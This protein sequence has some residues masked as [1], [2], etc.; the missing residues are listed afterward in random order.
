MM[1]T[2]KQ[3]GMVAALA[4]LGACGGG[5][6][7]ATTTTDT[8]G[9]AADTS[10]GEVTIACSVPNAPENDAYQRGARLVEQGDASGVALLDGACT[11]GNPCACSELSEVYWEGR[12]APTDHDRAITLADIAC[13]GGEIFGCWHAGSMRWLARPNE[14]DLAISRY[15]VACEGE[16]GEAC[17]ELGRLGLSGISSA[18]ATDALAF[19]DTACQNDTPLA[20]GFQGA[21][22]SEGEVPANPQRG[23]EL[24][25]FACLEALVPSACT[26]M[27]RLVVAANPGAA[28][29]A[30]QHA[31]DLHDVFACDALLPEAEAAAMQGTAAEALDLDGTG[32]EHA[33]IVAASTPSTI[34][35]SAGGDLDVAQLGLRPS[36]TGIIERE[37]DL[38]V[39]V[40]AGVPA[41]DLSIAALTDTTL[42][43]RDPAGGWHCAD[44]APNG[45]YQPSLHVA[46]PLAG[47]WVVWVGR[48]IHG[49]TQ[50][51]VRLG[52]APAAP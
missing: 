33:A 7:T 6:S 30:W 39:D 22:L 26:E 1:G 21:A 10:G 17:L 34:E 15:D 52:S 14:T 19:Y 49:E 51:T 43:V 29:E 37:A 48:F 18:S 8:G 25:E 40:G 24:L 11:A 47:E 31:C 46:T 28:R 36:C 20:C 12:L 50:A 16:N 42:V 41:L 44:D 32:A 3:T 5:T 13:E 23:A 38:V 27:G 45:S 2:T 35:V 9:G 4:L